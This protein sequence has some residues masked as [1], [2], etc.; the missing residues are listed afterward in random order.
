MWPSGKTSK[1]C[2]HREERP[3]HSGLLKFVTSILSIT[4]NSSLSLQASGV[5]ERDMLSEMSRPST[6]EL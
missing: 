2:D 3:G 5:T 4:R 1:K 6:D